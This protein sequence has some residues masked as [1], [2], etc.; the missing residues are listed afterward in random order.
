MTLPF[1]L[2]D[3]F[4]RGPFTGNPAG[5]VISETPLPD[6]VMQR[7][8]GEINQAET[9]F[10]VAL[11]G[12]SRFSLRWFTPTVEVDLCGHA[13]LAA[14]GI[15]FE[16]VFPGEELLTFETRSGEL[17]ARRLGEW[18]EL[19]FPA[20]PAQEAEFP[21][22]V[23][24]LETGVWEGTTGM[25]WLV[26]LPSEADVVRFQPDFPVIQELGL[27]GLIVTAPGD[28][29]DFVSR[30]FAPQSGV[31]EDSVTGS[32]HCALAPYWSQRLGKARMHA[33]QRSTRGGVVDCEVAGDRVLLRGRWRIV[34]SGTMDVGEVVA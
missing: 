23:A 19:D 33:A 18:I 11:G 3:A 21:A 30:F 28:E 7:I 5:V 1:Y 24:G 26:Q 12:R 16:R 20:L 31:P 10:L 22:A 9:S 2:V 8:A 17:T 32:A 14:A 13:T 29:F 4:H 25:D 15:L 27:R 6:D 34:V